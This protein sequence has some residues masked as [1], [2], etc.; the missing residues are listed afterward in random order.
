MADRNSRFSVKKKEKKVENKTNDEKD[1]EKEKILKKPEKLVKKPEKTPEQT[2]GEMGNK[3]S[4]GATGAEASNSEEKGEFQPMELPP[5]EI[6]T[7][8]V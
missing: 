6:V 5:F 1:K 8:W 3:K 4:E 2:A 7:G